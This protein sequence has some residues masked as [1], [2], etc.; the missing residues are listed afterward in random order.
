MF[1]YSGAQS[2]GER[3]A[4][5]DPVRTSRAAADVP[6]PADVGQPK[7]AAAPDGDARQAHTLRLTGSTAW[8]D[9][10]NRRVLPPVACR[11]EKV[12]V[13]VGEIVQKGDPFLELSSAELARA[14]DE[15]RNRYRQVRQV[16]E[17]SGPDMLQALK[18][19]K[20][21]RSIAHDELAGFGLTDE[22]I[23]DSLDED[24]AKKLRMTLRSPGDGLVT[25][26]TAVAG[27]QHGPTDELLELAVD[28]PLLIRADVDPRDATF[29]EIGQ[30]MTIHF[31][32]S[33][34]TEVANVEGREVN[35][36]TGK[37]TLR[38]SVPNP[39]HRFKPGTTV[40]IRL[41][42]GVVGNLHYRLAEVERK[43]ERLLEEKRVRTTNAEIRK[44][45][46]DLERKL[47]R[48]LE[49]RA[50]K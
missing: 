3:R 26:R 38:T 34:R 27:N 11:V 39:A 22:E 7:P 41:E 24:D 35:K 45:L 17:A 47:D 50:D 40:D 23:S 6:R 44:R 8:S 13:N 20:R 2:S 31:P 49:H 36:R 29:V 12:F 48:A 15:Y 9:I 1:W 4:D 5:G 16:I 33:D 14:K 43:L 19:A 18:A 32:F 30:R 10:R 42:L 28:D 21:E 25:A 46:D 37:F